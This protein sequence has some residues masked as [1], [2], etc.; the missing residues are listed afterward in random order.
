MN[1]FYNMVF[2]EAKVFG[3]GNL[4]E[5]LVVGHPYYPTRPAFLFLKKGKIKIREQINVFTLYENGVILIDSSSVYEILE[6]TQDIE[7]LIV[8]YHRRFIDALSF[9]FNRLNAYKSIRLEFKK[10]YQATKSEFA[11]M[12]QNVLNIQYYI[13]NLEA[14]EYQIEIIESLFSALV[15]QF[16]NI[17]AYQRKISKQK[18]SR[19]QEIALNFI[20]L[21]SLNFKKERNVEFY[22]QKLMLSSR[23]LTVVLKEVFGK[24]AIQILNEFVL[25]EAKAQ[26]SSS[27]KPINEISNDLKFSDQYSFS[28]FFKKHESLSPSQYRNQF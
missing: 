10:G 17:V 9:K 16:A 18:M 23:H 11:A 14:Q 8:A 20:K 12:W 13:D 4:L 22:A 21:V 25:N 26:L 24:S 15:Y 27:L 1:K 28:H 3:N 6:Y 5:H 2:E 19:S 7:V